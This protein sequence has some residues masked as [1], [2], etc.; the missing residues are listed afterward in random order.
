MQYREAY[1]AGKAVLAGTPEAELDARLLL[2]GVCGTSL[3]DLLAYPDREVREEEYAIYTEYL[4]SRAERV[5]VAYILGRQEFMGR[6]FEVTP[7]V[8]IPNQDTEHV[9]EEALKGLTAG[10]I[11]ILDLCTGSGCILLSLLQYSTD[12]TGI[13]TDISGEAL[14]VAA[15]NAERLGL[16][17]RC[18]FLQGD[19]FA[20][21]ED[22]GGDGCEKDRL[23]DLIIS[24]PPYIPYGALDGGEDGLVFYRRIAADAGKWLKPGGKLFLEIGDGQAEEVMRILEEAGFAETGSYKDYNGRD[25]VVFAERRVCI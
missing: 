10:G 3:K 2:E 13:G 18:R 19:L 25:R 7:D 4:R 20:A 21:L 11:R 12:T 14:E 5:P 23:F 17:E 22:R 16:S 9:V 1:E 6:D 15:R 8:L 24:N